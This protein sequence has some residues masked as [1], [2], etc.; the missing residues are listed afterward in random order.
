MKK[1]DMMVSRAKRVKGP[2]KTLEDYFSWNRPQRNIWKN[3]IGLSFVISHKMRPIVTA[4]HWS[5]CFDSKSGC[6]YR[7]D[8]KN[9]RKVRVVDILCC[10]A[11]GEYSPS[12]GIKLI[13]DKDFAEFCPRADFCGEADDTTVYIWFSYDDEDDFQ[14]IS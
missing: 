12:K 6:F 11:Q 1:T 13:E 8:S 2:F 9:V 4:E 14:K 7:I 10:N 3:S 5:V